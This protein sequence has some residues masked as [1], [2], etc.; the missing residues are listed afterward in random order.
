MR[1]AV[2]PAVLC[3]ATLLVAG[4]IEEP[5]ECNDP[6]SAHANSD[7]SIT[8]SWDAMPGSFA[9]SIG[10]KAGDEEFNP[11]YA[12]VPGSETNFTDTNT[13][14]GETYTYRVIGIG[15][16]TTTGCGR[17]T[18]TAVPFLADAA[19][20]SLALLGA[21]GAFVVLRRRRS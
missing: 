4:C 5:A 2:L 1:R 17:A 14:E 20:A 16:E 13:T 19:T 3:F 15:I 7:G 9:Y 18:T 8:V 10:R 6:V 21:V 11:N 12:A